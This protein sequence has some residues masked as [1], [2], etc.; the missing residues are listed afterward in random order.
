MTAFIDETLVAL[1]DP[2]ALQALLDPPGD[3]SHARVRSLLGAVYELPHA[4]LHEIRK[5]ELRGVEFAQ[6]VFAPRGKHGT[7]TQ[8]TPQY[9]RTD[10]TAREVDPLQ[11]VWVDVTARLA[12]TV[13]LEIDLGV[14]EAIGVQELEEFDTLEEFRAQFRY[15]DLDAFMAARGLTTVEELRAHARYLLAEVKLAAAGPFDP[16]DPANT[17]RYD[18]N[19]ALSLRDTLDVAAA[20]RSS[21]LVRVALEH[22]VTFVRETAT[23]EVRTPYAS[24]LVFPATALTDA[25]FGEEQLRRLFQT[26]RILILFRD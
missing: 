14:V 6:P 26:E 4:R 21:K 25:P 1:S 13:V 20:L 9:I 22:A 12:V 18:L 8:T 17:H 11:P 23:A 3:P 7:W 19:V 16:A 5:V 15:I 2:A 24:V 10:T